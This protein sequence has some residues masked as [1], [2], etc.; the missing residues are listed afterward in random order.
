[1]K[2]AY[3]CPTVEVLR[4]GDDIITQSNVGNG[5]YDDKGTWKDSWFN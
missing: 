5:D 4:L 1:M 2:K 3:E